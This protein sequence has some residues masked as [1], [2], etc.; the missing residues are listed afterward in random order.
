MPDGIAFIH[1]DSYAH[2][3]D[4]RGFF[5]AEPLTFSSRQA[6]LHEIG[7]GG[8]LWLV[9]R[10]P[11]DAQYYFAAV[12]A[13]V[14]HGNNAADS[15]TRANYGEYSVVADRSRS[16]DLAQRF[17]ADGLLRALHFESGKAINFGASVGQA[18]Q[19]IRLLGQSDELILDEALNRVDGNEPST[20][21]TPF[22]LWTKCDAVFTR[23]F[24]KNWTANHQRLAFLLYDSPPILSMGAP[25]FIHSDKS[26]RLVASFRGSQYVSGYK[27]TCDANERID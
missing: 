15:A 23:Y 11:T 8:R 10:H 25:V 7:S 20:L 26:L 24:L 16:L 5:A 2:G 9:S 13:I 12:L 22:G 21:E 27:P 18:L 6:R 3:L 14:G 1:W 19:T 17:P 4:G